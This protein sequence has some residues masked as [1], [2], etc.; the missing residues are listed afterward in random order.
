[1]RDV[2]GHS[3]L[4]GLSFFLFSSSSYKF[5]LQ[6]AFSPPSNVV[7]PELVNHHPAITKNSYALPVA[8]VKHK[9]ATPITCCIH[10]TINTLHLPPAWLPAKF[11]HPLEWH[12]ELNWISFLF[13]K[14]KEIA[15][16]KRKVIDKDRVIIRA[17]KSRTPRV[18]VCYQFGAT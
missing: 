1:M 18:R 4:Q 13:S 3:R 9:L 2:C 8:V 6:T 5:G 11:N 15:S 10:A 16:A 7:T 17:C 12:W 14:G